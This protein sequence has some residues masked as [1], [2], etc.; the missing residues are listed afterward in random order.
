MLIYFRYTWNVYLIQYQVIVPLKRGYILCYVIH[1]M[2][3]EA[4][5]NRSEISFIYHIYGYIS[6]IFMLLHAR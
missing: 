4:H 2:W 3:M 1:S 6:L 5:R